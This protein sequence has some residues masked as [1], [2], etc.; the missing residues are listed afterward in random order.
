MTS[1]QA[2]EYDSRFFLNPGSA[3]G[4]WTGSLSGCVIRASSFSLPR[5]LTLFF[6]ALFFLHPAPSF[7]LPVSWISIPTHASQSLPPTSSSIRRTTSFTV[8]SLSNSH[9]SPSLDE[10]SRP[11]SPSYSTKSKAR[12]RFSLMDLQRLF[13]APTQPMQSE[14]HG[15]TSNS[16]PSTVDPPTPKDEAYHVQ[17]SLPSSTVLDALARTPE[18]AKTPRDADVERDF[19][20]EMRLDSFHFDSLSF[21]PDTFDVR[22]L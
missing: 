1:F 7:L 11:V 9:T 6:L 3:S 15:E 8:S 19:S 20:F 14:S 5:F 10:E 22:N 13:S 4:A 16:L 18:Q 2:V 21:D 12:R 17:F